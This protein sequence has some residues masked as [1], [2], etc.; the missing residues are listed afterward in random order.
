MGMNSYARGRGM[1]SLE[2]VEEVLEDKARGG[3]GD[4][5]AAHPAS[6]PS[7]LRP[8]AVEASEGL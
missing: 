5:D 6:L 7:G 2:E 1:P 8:E 4:G 3:G